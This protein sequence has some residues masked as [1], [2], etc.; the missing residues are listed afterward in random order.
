MHGRQKRNSR[1]RNKKRLTCAVCGS[2]HTTHPTRVFRDLVPL[3]PDC[4]VL[5][6]SDIEFR[7]GLAELK[8]C[9]TWDGFI[10]GKKR[11]RFERLLHHG[12]AQVIE[13]AKEMELEDQLR[14][15]I[16]A[17][18]KSRDRRLDLLTEAFQDWLGERDQRIS[19]ELWDQLAT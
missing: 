1:N 13:L 7:I 8:R 10:V 5:S 18:S 9:R 6:E 14:S 2:S 12:N 15:E 16:S 11:K 3:C 17:A 4:R 19:E